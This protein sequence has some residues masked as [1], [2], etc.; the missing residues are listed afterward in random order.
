VL[1]TNFRSH[2]GIINVVNGV[3]RSVIRASGDLQPAYEEIRPL[4]GRV[5]TTAAQSVELVLFEGDNEEALAATEARR[6]EAAWIAARIKADVARVKIPDAE[7]RPTVLAYRHIAILFKALTDVHLTL[8]ALRGAD[9]PYVVEGEKYFYGTSEIVDF[10]NLLRAIADPHD[11]IAVA[12][13]LRSP[14][15]AVDDVRLF[16]MRKELD[17]REERAGEPRIFATLRELHAL[18]GKTAVAPFIDVVFE[19][20]HVLETAA[21]SWHGEQAVANLLK[22]RQ[23]AH[24]LEAQGGLTLRRFTARVKESVRELEEEGE[25]PLADETLDAVRVMS[26]HK[27][28]GLEF[29]VVVLPD[30][31]RRIEDRDEGEPVRF[32]WPT[33]T[34]GVRM[35]GVCD[36]GGAALSWL[37]SRRRREEAR[38]VLYVAMTRPREAL[39]LTGAANFGT[40]SNLGLLEEATG[41]LAAG[42]V[43][44]GDGEIAV[45]RHEWAGEEPRARARELRT[46]EPAGEPALKALA[47]RWRER[48]AEREAL[49]A[50][51]RFTSPSR[52]KRE[53][54]R[55]KREE[56]REDES[57][58][59]EEGRRERAAEVGTLCHRVLQRMDFGKP[60]V[61][62][63]VERL[64]TDP[65]VAAEARAILERYVRSAAFRRIAKAKVLARELPFLMRDG[66]SVVQGAI[67][68]VIREGERVTVVDYKSSEKTGEEFAEQ[69]EWYVRAVEEI[70]GVRGAEFWIVY[71]RDTK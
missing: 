28:K 42:K 2:S 26:V 13:L 41:R 46:V 40:S 51:P 62:K 66:E 20:T 59:D 63:L 43:K 52:K 53:E 8:E 68:L 65:A 27:A 56:K 48:R 1:R 30:L 21:A 50:T 55:G 11:R 22:I 37:E 34:L 67:D 39:I 57:L 4:E 45:S 70:L 54:G 16:A 69:R 12:G 14:L 35:G 5:A 60:E 31:H 32:D 7:G 47:A 24:A 17:Y 25:S 29:P 19:R 64:A 36:A 58:R 44:A 10:I 6:A 38:R 49:L 33:Y 15:G 9:V 71:L 61:V 18:S 3:F 23:T